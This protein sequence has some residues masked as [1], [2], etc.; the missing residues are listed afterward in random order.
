[1]VEK[2]GWL[3]PN[4]LYFLLHIA[5]F[6]VLEILAVCVLWQFGTGWLPWLTSML[7]FVAS[8]VGLLAETDL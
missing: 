6:L 4:H 1:M 3:K 7:L 2:N 8:Q 5:H